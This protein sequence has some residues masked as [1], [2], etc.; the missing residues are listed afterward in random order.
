MTSPRLQNRKPRRLPTF[1]LFVL[2]LVPPSMAGDPPKAEPAVESSPVEKLESLFDG[3]TLAKWKLITKYDFEDHGSVSVK[4]GAIHLEE[5]RPATGIR[6]T[7]EMPR[8][9][10]ELSFDAMRVEGGDFFVGLTFP[11]G[12][13]NCSW[14]VGGWGGSIVGLS[15]INDEPAAENETTQYMRFENKR[16]YHLRLR[17]TPTS[18]QGWI[19]GK[20]V[21]DVKT[22]NRKFSIWWE[23]EPALPLGFST[24]ITSA[25]LK[26][27]RLKHVDAPAN[28]PDDKTRTDSDSPTP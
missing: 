22:E 2:A 11:V 3:K 4:D 25:A 24:W 15:N 17:V 8:T 26:N 7:G 6:W 19:D 5:G 18:V 13:S 14:I 1:V 21:I 28:P 12:E 9:N 16:W 27:I 10:Y 20:P 23:Q